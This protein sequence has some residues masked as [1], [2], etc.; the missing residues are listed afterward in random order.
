[1]ATFSR[2]DFIKTAGLGAA[3]IGL[4][5]LPAIRATMSGINRPHIVLFMSDDHG[6]LDSSPYGSKVVRTPNLDRL[7]RESMRFTLAFAASPTC[8]PSRS[9]LY[10]GRMP[11]RNGAHRNHSSVREGL[12]TL[13]HYFK[14]LGYRVVLA[15]KVHVKPREAFPFEYLPGANRREPG[16]GRGLYMDLHTPAVDTLLA[17][18]D[19]KRPLCLI[20]CSHSPHVYWPPNKEYDASAIDIPPTHV[21]TPV[22]RRVRTEYYTDVTLMDKRLGE[23]MASLEKHGYAG[24]LLF[25]YTSDQ[26]AQWPFAKWNLY[27]GGIQVPLLVRWPGK[28][29]P[30]SKTDAMVSLVDLLPTFMEAAGGRPPQDIDGRSFLPVLLGK[31]DKHRDVIFATHTRDGRMNDSPM[32]CIRTSTHKYVLNLKPD[33]TYTTHI[34]NGN[35]QDGRDYWESWLEQAKTDE[36]AAQI[37]RR[38]QHRPAE[39]L[40]D[41][42]ADPYETV[43]IADDPANKELVTRLRDR[44][45]AWRKQQGEAEAGPEPLPETPR[46]ERR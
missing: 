6:V 8:A 17:A 45:A 31:K 7:A 41:L 33:N 3:G 18:H 28:I 29:R 23:V 19:K 30:G 27:D 4:Y 44:L 12:K 25:A 40:Y 21:D 15:G 2:R 32:R 43:N 13:P 39:E 24:N 22:T 14:E 9:A 34:T 42:R 35:D 1:M 5:G 38:Y 46:R 10:T 16:K 11:F 26:G 36:H 20:V 37:V